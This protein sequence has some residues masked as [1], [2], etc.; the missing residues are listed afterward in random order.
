M[1][2]MNKI[3]KKDWKINFERKFPSTDKSREYFTFMCHDKDGEPTTYEMTEKQMKQFERAQFKR[4]IR[5]TYHNISHSKGQPY[6]R[7]PI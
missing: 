7:C 6:M 3:F 1:K 4:S 2:R 5:R